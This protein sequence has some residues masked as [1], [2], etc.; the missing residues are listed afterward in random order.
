M[1]LRVP[2]VLSKPEAVSRLGVFFHDSRVVS[3]PALQNGTVTLTLHRIGYECPAP[4]ERR[5]L[6]LIRWRLY[7]WIPVTINVTAVEGIREVVTA[8][9]TAE[10]TNDISFISLEEQEL[11]FWC[12]FK[13]FHLTLSPESTLSI[14][15]AGAPLSTGTKVLGGSGLRTDGIEDLLAASTL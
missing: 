2:S 8:E 1:D 5:W 13:E 3:D 6:G 15:D 12:S 7:P 9:G 14:Q 11:V 10:L 4:E